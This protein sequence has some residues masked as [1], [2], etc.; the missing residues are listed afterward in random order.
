MS[1]IGF[2]QL[3]LDDRISWWERNSING[4]YDQAELAANQS[5]ANT[6]VINKHK[7]RLDQMAREIVMLR[8]AV[9]VL[10]KTLRDTNVIDPRLLD[11]RLEAAME[12]A[13]SAAPQPHVPGAPQAATAATQAA[14]PPVTCI[15]CRKQVP[16]TTT[17][18]TADGPACDR[19]PT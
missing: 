12:E 16:A 2:W 10:V 14:V 17:T 15:R 1:R 19:C 18:M 7:D 9:T 6:F 5:D 13:A 11:A 8:T 3:L 4:A